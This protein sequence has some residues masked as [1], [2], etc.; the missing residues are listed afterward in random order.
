MSI[1]TLLAFFL[2]SSVTV[3]VLGLDYNELET[4]KK[5]KL[6]QSSMS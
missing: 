3:I 2:V 1:S 5:P 6:Q 4:V